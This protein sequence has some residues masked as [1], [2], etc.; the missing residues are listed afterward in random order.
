MLLLG[1]EHGW[2]GEG[3][4]SMKGDTKGRYFKATFS[5]AIGVI[6]FS[7]GG[8]RRGNIGEEGPALSPFVLSSPSVLSLSLSEAL[9]REKHKRA[10]RRREGDGLTTTSTKDPLLSLSLP[11]FLLFFPKVQNSPPVM[12]IIPKLQKII[13]CCTKPQRN[14]AHST[15]SLNPRVVAFPLLHVSR[16]DCSRGGGTLKEGENQEELR[17]NPTKAYFPPPLTITGKT[18]HEGTGRRTPCLYGREERG[19]GNKGPF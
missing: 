6:F 5:F 7:D 16:P 4:G 18:T 3:R 10:Q 19:G 1:E 14:I 17:E 9:E 13:L 15:S 2:D 8:E 12:E 11:L